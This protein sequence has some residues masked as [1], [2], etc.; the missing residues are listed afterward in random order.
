M[1]TKQ[2]STIQKKKE[3]GLLDQYLDT[4]QSGANTVKNNTHCSPI[5]RRKQALTENFTL[6]SGPELKQK[7]SE[8]IA[9]HYSH[10]LLPYEKQEILKFSQVYYIGT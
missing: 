10:L 9:K 4:V 6:A 8:S 5:K 1:M 7:S 2:K 3:S